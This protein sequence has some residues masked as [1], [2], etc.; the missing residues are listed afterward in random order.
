MLSKKRRNAGPNATQIL[1]TNR[2]AVTARQVVAV[3]RRRWAVAVLSKELQG[4][5]GFGQ[6]QVPN[7]PQRGERAVAIAMM[8]DLLLLKFRWHDM[9]EKGPWSIFTRKHNFS[10]QLGQAQ[11]ERSVEQR[12]RKGL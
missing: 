6:H 5:T 1:V 3:Y 7:A 9:P 12:L 8:A 2:P 11:L 4:G 10:W